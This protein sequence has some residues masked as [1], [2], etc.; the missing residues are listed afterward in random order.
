MASS[1]V[2]VKRKENEEL[3]MKHEEYEKDS[4]TNDYVM[5]CYDDAG[6][7]DVDLRRSYL[8]DER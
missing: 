4:F 5:R 2:E 1:S 3:R 8:H 6:A 7:D